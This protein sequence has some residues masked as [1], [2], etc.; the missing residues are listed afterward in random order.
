V[1]YGPRRPVPTKL[2]AYEAI[3]EA[4]LT[5]YPALSSVRLLEEIRAAGYA[6]SYT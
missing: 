2:D 5:A 3:V 6:G 1:R 4:R